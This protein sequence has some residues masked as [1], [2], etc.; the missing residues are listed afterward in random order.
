[1]LSG[2]RKSKK[3]IKIRIV[4]SGETLDLRLGLTAACEIEIGWS[5]PGRTNHA[6]LSTASHGRPPPFLLLA[7]PGLSF[8]S[9]HNNAIARIAL[10]SNFIPATRIFSYTL[11]STL[12]LTNS[13]LSSPTLHRSLYSS[14]NSN[15]PMPTV[16]LS[17]R[18]KGQGPRSRIP[19]CPARQRWRRGRLEHPAQFHPDLRLRNVSSDP[20]FIFLR[21]R[22]GYVRA[23]HFWDTSCQARG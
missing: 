6:T 5:G 18:I 12:L 4:E 17:P 15:E 1:M 16:S 22:H 20:F 21:G 7:Q 11:S 3:E 13:P 10:T 23:V 9:Y 8:S 2:R 14:N 19:A